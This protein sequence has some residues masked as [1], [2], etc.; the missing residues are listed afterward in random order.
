MSLAH[1]GDD[2]P[3]HSVVERADLGLPFDALIGGHLV[4]A[5]H[6][7]VLLRDAVHDVEL[8]ST[9]DEQDLRRVHLGADRECDSGLC[10]SESSFGAFF[11][12]QTTISEPFHVK[13][14]GTLRG[15]LSLAT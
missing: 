11:G 1:R 5:V 15:V 12:V 4:G 13:A 9:A 6:L 2:Y 10:R 8:G 3:D 14:I 7:Q